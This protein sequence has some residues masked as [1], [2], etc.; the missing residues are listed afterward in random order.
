MTVSTAE[1]SE[2]C[3]LHASTLKR[4]TVLERKIELFQW[5]SGSENETFD[6]NTVKTRIFSFFNADQNREDIWTR[7][8]IEQAKLY[9][10]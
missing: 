5:N 4:I 1:S 10:T 6:R 7:Q 8:Q 3:S 9:K 2:E